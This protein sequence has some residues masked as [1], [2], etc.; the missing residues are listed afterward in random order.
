MHYT[1]KRNTFVSLILLCISLNFL[2]ASTDSNIETN[3]S[4]EACNFKPTLSCPPFVWLKPIESDDPSRT[5]TAQAFPG[6]PGCDQPN[7]SY[8]DEVQII[9][10]CH[11]IITRIWRAEDPN[12]PSLFDTCHQTIKVVDEE[13]PVITYPPDDI[14]IYTNTVSCKARASWLNPEIFDNNLLDYFEYTDHF[15]GQN[16]VVKNGD[17]FEEG[18]HEITLTAYDFCG[19]ISSHK[20]IIDIMCARCHVSCPDDACL[21]VGSDIS[22][23]VLGYASSYTGN[24]NC[25]AAEIDFTDVIMETGCNGKM[26]YLRVWEAEFETMPGFI[27]NCVQEIEL[28]NETEIALHNCPGDLVIEN[29]FTPVYWEYPTATN[30]NIIT[31]LT[32]NY[33]PGT[34]FPVGITTVIY[35]ATDDCGNEASCSFKVSVLE[36]ISFDDCPDDIFLSCDEDGTATPTWTAPTYNG[37]CSSCGPGTPLSG[38]IYIG[39]LN[40]SQYYCSAHFYTY[41]QAKTRAAQLG[42]HVVSINSR[43]ENEFIASHI[44][45]YSAM[46]GLSDYQSEGKFV[47]DSGESLDYKNWFSAQPNDRGGIQDY[48][49]L[50]KSSGEWNDV[51]NDLSMEFVLEIPCTYVKQIKGPK[52]GHPLDPGTYSVVYEITDGC[53]LE[54]FCQFDINISGGISVKNCPADVVLEGSANGSVAYT[55]HAPFFYT[56]CTNCNSNSCIEVTRTGPGSGQLLLNGTTSIVTYTGVDP[57]GNFIS[58]SFSITIEEY[59]Q[60]SIIHEIEI[61]S[62]MTGLIENDIDITDEVLNI[63]SVKSDPKIES[64]GLKIY[65]NPVQSILNIDF[66]E[67]DIVSEINIL[68]LDGKLSKNINTTFDLKNEI[69]IEH[70]APGMYFIQIQYRNKI[71]H[72]ER[73]LKF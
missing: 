15:N 35:L 57:C 38:F 21:P 67:S 39:A 54:E 22:P 62:A 69:N 28:K 73:L 52:S 42:G 30:G 47:W 29:N 44:G 56:C 60:N 72:I 49:E 70:L 7:V 24:V 26:K 33:E 11:L 46:I 37:T 50:I 36:D 66:D 8:Y 31:Y 18:V 43:E 20:F 2:T 64:K 48:V 25:G 5:G 19:N 10:S 1:L 65:P 27:Y 23:D 34:L 41:A 4:E 51:D 6:G 58:C 45:G 17:F 55:W 71:Q 53:G 3:N 9:N 32:S 63:P 59:V 12:N 13:A 14:M 16:S 40:G 61:G 68:T